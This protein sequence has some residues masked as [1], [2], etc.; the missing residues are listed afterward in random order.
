MSHSHKE[1]KIA[2]AC[3]WQNVMLVTAF[4]GII[5]CQHSLQFCSMEIM[6]QVMMQRSR[7]TRVPQEIE[8]KNSKIKELNKFRNLST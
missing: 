7:I 2:G 6:I 1:R 8:T 4:S 3:Y 5:S